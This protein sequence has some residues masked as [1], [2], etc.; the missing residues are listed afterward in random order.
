MPFG[1]HLFRRLPAI[2]LLLGTTPLSGQHLTSRTTGDAAP[3]P[4]KPVHSFDLSS[5]DKSVD[6]C[7]NFYQ[8]AC[9]NWRKNNPI[10]ADEPVWVSFAVLDQRNQY[11]LYKELETAADSPKTPLQQQYGGY[12]AACMD[13]AAIDARGAKPL[14]PSL[15]AIAALPDKG[16]IAALLADP[17]YDVGGFADFGAEPDQKDA[18]HYIAGVYQGGL[19]LPDRDY[20][21]STEA[22]MVEIRAKYH[23]YIVTLMKLAGDSPE[24]AEKIAA[25]VIRIET[26]LAKASM[27]RE[28]MR[29]PDNIYHPMPVTELMSLTPDFNWIAYFKTVEAPPFT[30]V[31]VAQPDFFKAM[32][33]LVDAEPLPALRNYLRFQTV[34]GAAT[35]LARP[36][37]EAHFAFFGKLLEGQAEEEAR[38][39]RCTASTD[40]ALGEAVGQDWVRENFPPRAKQDMEVLVANLKSAL[41]DDIAAL[42]WMSDATK[43]EAELKLSQFRQKI[44]YPD[45]WRDYSGVTVARDDW[46]GDA[47]R[48][49]IF[50]SEFQLN[51]IGK[52]VDESEWG[53]TPPTV[54]AYYNGSMNDINFPAG[55]LQPPFYQLSIDPAVNY[56][57]I[58]AVIGHE[59]T[60]GFDDEGSRF[61]GL[62]NKRDWFT[63]ED[64]TKFKEKTDCEVKEY[65]SFEPIPGQK[66]NGNLTL[67]ENT[68]DNGGIRIAYQALENVM[69]GEPAAARSRKIDGY[70]PDQRFFIAFAQIWCENARPDYQQEMIKVDPHSPGEFRTN[71]VVENFDQFGRA[72]GCH[73]GQ[74]MMPANRCQ[75]W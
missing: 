35:R 75:V 27:S 37:D 56:G 71:G 3:S 61:D 1:S 20:Y 11:L 69:A 19:T 59:M 46:F 49:S 5:I 43:K 55:I 68:A 63:P 64:R 47:H 72:F 8:Y 30:R 74:P 51:H 73:T 34:N 18:S 60:H 52:P 6:P 10:P 15:A 28:A 2:A 48:A 50:N 36:F 13:D 23:D 57:S 45:T 7:S 65:G 67:G 53:M 21:L 22:H 29:E 31:N 32:N 40:R 44:G 66:L 70:T 58:G 12:F 42:P 54:N 25:D 39:K 62:G 16:G 33:S 41:H 26:A 14:A 24:S 38:W 4:P 17:R 9:G